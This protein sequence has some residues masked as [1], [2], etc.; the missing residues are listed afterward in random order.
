[1]SD[2]KITALPAVPSAVA[3][4]DVLPLVQD[5]SS[6]PVT[7]KSTISQLSTAVYADNAGFSGVASVSSV[8]GTDQT[9][10]VQ[11]GNN[12]KGTITQ[13]A[14]AVLA[15]N[16]AL[17]ALPNASSVT[18]TDTTVVAQS[19]TNREATIAQ[20]SAAVY[21]DNAALVGLP[22]VAS[23]AN[24]DTLVVAQ[25]GTNKE[26]TML[27][28]GA[29]I[30]A[31]SVSI[32]SL[33]AVTGPAVRTGAAPAA[34]TFA[35]S[36]AGTNKKVTVTQ[37][38]NPCMQV[39]YQASAVDITATGVGTFVA[40]TK[41]DSAIGYFTFGT[42]LANAPV[43]LYPL[44]NS[45]SGTATFEITDN[46]ACWT[47]L[48]TLSLTGA[49]ER[50]EYFFTASYQAAVFANPPS[51]AGLYLYVASS[52]LTSPNTANIYIMGVPT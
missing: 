32:T 22:N 24:A 3:S 44:A 21:A 30:I 9:L 19:G 43:I 15:D 52:N 33:S 37:I 48:A 23:V 6:T 39:I 12:R 42:P 47:T 14:T 41:V 27:Q 50:R 18:G 10:I 16:T 8:S 26:A 38:R 1:M 17:V 11:S 7:R 51:G 2:V 5:V 25:S 4:T 31:Q 40:L 36:D 20:I 28:A 35:A 49:T 29:N 45:G 13:V 34:M 46:T